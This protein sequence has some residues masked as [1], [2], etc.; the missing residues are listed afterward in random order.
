MKQIVRH[1]FVSVSLIS[2]LSTI[3]A[4][5]LGNY[6]RDH[7]TPLMRAV[8]AGNISE[9][10]ELL[11]TSNEAI[12]AKD[13]YKH[14]PLLMAAYFGKADVI[15]ELLKAGADVNIQGGDFDETALMLAAYRGRPDVVK[16]LLGVTGIDIYL[17]NSRGQTAH[18]LTSNGE[19][20]H[21]LREA[22]DRRQELLAQI[23]DAANRN[24]HQAITRL[25]NDVSVKEVLTKHDVKPILD[26]AALTVHWAD[27]VDKYT[28]QYVNPMAR[29]GWNLLGERLPEFAYKHVLNPVNTHLDNVT[30]NIKAP[31]Q[32]TA[33]GFVAA[34]LLKYPFLTIYV[35]SI[36]ATE[37]LLIASW[38]VGVA[39]IGLLHYM[40]K[41]E[42]K[43]ILT[44]LALK[45][46]YNVLPAAPKQ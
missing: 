22:G 38:G 12:N 37:A 11:K 45:K 44:Y 27:Y 46:L 42:N 39:P 19:I 31:D 25:I 17:K 32:A 8:C 16:E 6:Y 4:E 34:W 30:K 3:Q 41:D 23:E 36:G 9:V 21:L 29:K 35:G 24:D 20:L 33:L 13:E 28:H 2:L 18:M 43:K 26:S 7:G 5:E 40:T 10:Q 1:L 15:K 14:T